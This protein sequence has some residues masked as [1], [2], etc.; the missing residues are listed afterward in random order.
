MHRETWVSDRSIFSIQCFLASMS[1]FH[2]CISHTYSCGNTFIFQLRLLF[3]SLCQG[4]IFSSI[5]F[6]RKLKI[7]HS[8]IFSLNYLKNNYYCIPST[9]LF[10]QKNISLLTSKRHL[11]A[12]L[13][14]CLFIFFWGHTNWFI[15]LTVME[16]DKLLVPFNLIRNFK[17][18]IKSLQNDN[19]LKI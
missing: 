11:K 2:S 6:F 5:F 3:K 7:I 19:L 8:F 14:V 10:S 15:N 1:S 18:G 4:V 13:K 16:E 17:K 9:L 12:L